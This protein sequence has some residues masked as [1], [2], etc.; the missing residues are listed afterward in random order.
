MNGAGGVAG[1]EQRREPGR[2]RTNR[3]SVG[4]EQLRECR[5][6]GELRVDEVSLDAGMRQQV[7][8]LDL[9]GLVDRR[10]HRSAYP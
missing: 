3:L 8:R 1:I 9:Q 10:E 5:P 2:C 4:A 6:T 7:A